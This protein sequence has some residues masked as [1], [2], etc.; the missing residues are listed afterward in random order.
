MISASSGHTA[1]EIEETGRGGERGEEGGRGRGEGGIL[2]DHFP[3]HLPSLG[4]QTWYSPS[5]GQSV[6]WAGSDLLP[7]CAQHCWM[8]AARRLACGEEWI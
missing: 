6:V 8:R 7:R 1:T 3:N 2:K 5:A 4:S